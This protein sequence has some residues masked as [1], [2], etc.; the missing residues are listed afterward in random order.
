M[1]HLALVSLLGMG[2]PTAAP[3]ALLEH[4]TPA[5]RSERPNIRIRTLFALIARCLI[6]TVDRPRPPHARITLLASLDHSPLKCLG[7]PHPF[8]W[9]RLSSLGASEARLD[10]VRHPPA[11]RRRSR[12][13]RRPFGQGRN[14]GVNVRKL[15]IPFHPRVLIYNHSE[16]VV[17]R[18]LATRLRLRE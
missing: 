1:L 15:L 8:G 17:R 4:G 13:S 11:P 12:H 5:S 3:R 18:L 2:L 7:L 6:S 14:C 10:P 16:N 9:A